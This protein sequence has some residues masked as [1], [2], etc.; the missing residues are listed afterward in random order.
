MNAGMIATLFRPINAY[1]AHQQ[2]FELSNT[3]S[4]SVSAVI[5]AGYR[6]CAPPSAT[7]KDWRN[8]DSCNTEPTDAQPPIQLMPVL[9]HLPRQE[10]KFVFTVDLRTHKVA[11]GR[12]CRSK[13]EILPCTL[14]CR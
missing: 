2:G 14:E 10:V 7:P 12:R 6:V 9:Q 4:S 13:P 8:T 3:F 5:V 11:Q 1:R